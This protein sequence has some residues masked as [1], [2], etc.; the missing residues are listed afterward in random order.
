MS[1]DDSDKMPKS[2]RDGEREPS[3]L[4]TRD[5]QNHSSSVNHHHNPATATHLRP[6]QHNSASATPAKQRSQSKTCKLDSHILQ[7]SHINLLVLFSVSQ[8]NRVKEVQKL[9]FYF[10][11]VA[12][13]SLCSEATTHQ[14]N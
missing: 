1:L 7:R 10:E 13:N 8:P 4:Q 12:A 9:G 5:S 6:A 3:N 11:A 14:R 2:Y